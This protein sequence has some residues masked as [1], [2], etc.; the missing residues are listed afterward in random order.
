MTRRGLRKVLPALAAVCHIM[1]W[2]IDPEPPV[3]TR[4]ELLE[5]VDYTTQY[6]TGGSDG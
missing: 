5:F 1:P 4:D 6:L 3:L 2:H